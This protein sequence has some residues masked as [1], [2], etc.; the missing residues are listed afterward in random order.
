MEKQY[1][2]L[3]LIPSRP[4][5]AMTM[6]DDERA[7]MGAHV[8]YWTELMNKGKVVVFGPVMD[9]NGVYGFGVI[10]A[11]SDEEVT[12]FIAGDPAGK[13]NKYEYYPMR[14]IVPAAK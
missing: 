12:G 13:I 4:D 2:A 8:A 10:S 9:P 5:F 7:I 6:T 3:K 1:Y 14:A 11:D